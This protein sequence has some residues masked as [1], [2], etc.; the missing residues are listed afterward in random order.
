MGAGD[1][2][3]GPPKGGLDTHRTPRSPKRAA[4]VVT[5]L[6]SAFRPV[7]TIPRMVLGP[8]TSSDRTER[9]RNRPA[10][11]EE[12]L[13]LPGRP[14]SRGARDRRDRPARRDSR[15]AR[16]E[17]RGQVDDG[18]PAARPPEARRGSVAVFG[19]PPDH[20]VRAG[21]IGVMLQAGGVLRDLTVRELVA[22]M[23]ALFPAPL[24]VDATL[25]LAQ[26]QGIADRR[27][28][29]AERR[30]DAAAALRGG[31]RQR[32]RPPRP[33]R[34]HGRH[35]RR[36]E[37]RVL[38]DDSRPLRARQDVPVRN[39]LPRGG[40]RLCGPRRPDG[41]RPRRRRQADHRDQGAR[42]HAHDPG[43]VSGRPA[44]TSS[45]GCPA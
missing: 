5:P 19:G 37:A 20:A 28:R 4:L 9:R 45:N 17:R 12:D 25:A 11:A 33:R 15:A 24:D 32:S 31:A 39:A 16:A 38:D 36:V 6:G 29:A 18:R 13:Q 23:A 34:A 43:D 1:S 27:T 14:R 26:L 2:G 41:A 8:A 30:R 22:M 44:S 10:R 42:R 40:R 3:E 21:R 35:G 7:Y